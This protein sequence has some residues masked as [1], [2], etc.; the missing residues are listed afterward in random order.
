MIKP[1]GKDLSNTFFKKFPFTWAK[2]ASYVKKKVGIP[3]PQALIKD[4]W[5]GSKG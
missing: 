4:N 5:I 2:L 3:T 1:D